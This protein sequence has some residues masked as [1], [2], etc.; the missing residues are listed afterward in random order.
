[1]ITFL[2]ILC[3]GLTLNEGLR[4]CDRGC[5][6][7]HP[8]PC[9]SYCSVHLYCDDTYKYRKGLDCRGCSFNHYN[10]KRTTT[11][12]GNIKNLIGQVF[13]NTDLPQFSKDK[14]K[15]HMKINATMGGYG[16]IDVAPTKETKHGDE[17]LLSLTGVKA[18][19]DTSPLAVSILVVL[20]VLVVLDA[21]VLCALYYRKCHVSTA[22]LDEETTTP[23]LNRRN[24]RVRQEDDMDKQNE[25]SHPDVIIIQHTTI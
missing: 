14:K 2:T 11:N 17:H 5:E 10:Y 21:V 4:Y 12:L 20:L 18:H 6:S 8:F 13:Y 22:E 1:M 15:S 7:C 24:E 16:G 19:F 23:F 9:N 3:L 25:S